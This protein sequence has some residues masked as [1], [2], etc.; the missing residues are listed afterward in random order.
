MDRRLT[1]ANT[2]VAAAALKGM[3]MAESFVEGEAACIRA[4]LADLCRDPAGDRDRQLL[5]GARVVVYERVSGWAFVQAAHDGY[6]GYVPEKALGPTVKPTHRI[7]ARTTHLYPE[8]D[9]KTRETA[10]LSGGS[11]VAVTGE[12]GR[13]AETTAGFIPLQHLAPLGERADPLVVARVFMGTPYLWGGNS[14]AGIDCSGLVQIALLAAG[15]DC[16]GDSDLQ[17]AAVGREIDREA[18]V[19][20]CDLFFWKGHVAMAL[21]PETLIH[22]TAHYMSVVAEPLAEALARIEKDD[23][24]LRTRRRL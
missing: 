4:P 20:P 11:V 7:A 21:D 1:P 23:S 8:P 14:G 18:P 10:A 9:M 3:V 12:T 17:E 24:P 22:A 19:E 15:H 2:R 5:M 13:F 16:P 6:V